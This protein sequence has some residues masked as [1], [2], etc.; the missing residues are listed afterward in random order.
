MKKIVRI[1]LHLNIKMII[2]LCFLYWY[3]PIVAVLKFF[4][5]SRRRLNCCVI[6][7]DVNMDGAWIVE[8]PTFSTGRETARNDKV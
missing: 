3:S 5:L 2:I 8:L 7:I 1:S 4:M 6:I